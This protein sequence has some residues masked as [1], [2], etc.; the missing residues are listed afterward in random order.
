MSLRAVLVLIGAVAVAAA[1]G[2]MADPGVDA[3]GAPTPDDSTLSVAAAGSDNRQAGQ[4][5]APSVVL[6]GDPARGR[7]VFGPCRT[8]HYPDK[9]AG[10]Q[11]GPSL[12]NI[13]GR[14]AGTQ[15]GFAYYSEALKNSGIV[16]TPEYLDAWLA[17]PIGFIPGTAMMTLGVA[18]GQGRADL[19]AYLMQFREAARP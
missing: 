13:F 15:E 4:A 8:C 7:I 3:T 9:G 18:D 16:W 11:N 19:I 14:T 2:A 1:T 17:D 10:H 12:W 6:Q 5:A